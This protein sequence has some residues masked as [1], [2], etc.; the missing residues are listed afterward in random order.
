MIIENK[1]NELNDKYYSYLSAIEESL[2]KKELTDEFFLID[3][4]EFDNE[5]IKVLALYHP[6]GEFLREVVAFLK[7]SSFL[8]KIKKSVKAFIKKYDFKNEKIDALYQNAISAITTLKLAAKSDSIEDA[9]SSII[10]YEKIADELYKELVLD[11]K[12]KENIDE[13]LKALNIAKKLERIS[14]SVKT[15]AKY[16]LFAKEGIDI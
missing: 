8:A 7:I 4:K 10:S 6:Q 5:V 11:V 9:Y 16:M 3:L 14:D 12:E 15:I 1:I 2:Q 13:I